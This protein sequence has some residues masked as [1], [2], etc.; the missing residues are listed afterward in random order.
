MENIELKFSYKKSDFTRFTFYSIRKFFIYILVIIFAMALFTSFKNLNTIREQAAAKN[1]TFGVY[2]FSYNMAFIIHSFCYAYLPC[3]VIYAALMFYRS[4]RL[5]NKGI[6]SR[7]EH[8]IV[9]TSDTITETTEKHTLKAQYSDIKKV[10]NTS[11]LLIIY[12][13]TSSAL[14]IP[15]TP[16]T[17]EKIPA[18]LEVL[19]G[20]GMKV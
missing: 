16:E 5:Y 19:K 3:S 8:Q 14:L 11:K 10:A 4:N 15:K 12:L 13:N 6:T 18:I 7:L 17:S 2:F 20:N 9:F 1:F